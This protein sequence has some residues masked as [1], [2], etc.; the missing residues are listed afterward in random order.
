MHLSDQGGFVRY[1]YF[2]GV[3][4]FS[5]YSGFGDS[6]KWERPYEDLTER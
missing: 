4:Q 2:P 6:F 3:E 1:F 5:T